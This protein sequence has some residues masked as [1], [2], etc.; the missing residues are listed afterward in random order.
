MTTENIEEL[1]A[2]LLGADFGITLANQ[3]VA[4]VRKEY[5]SQG[6]NG[7]SIFEIAR[8]E[9]ISCFPLET[10]GLK[11]SD[12]EYPVVVSLIGVN[13]VGKTTTAAKLAYRVAKEGQS[14]M[15]AACDTFRAAAIEQLK[16]WGNR[17]DVPVIAGSYGADPASVAHDAVC[18][19]ISNRINYLF[20]D[21]AGRLHTKNNLMQELQKV[22]RVIGKRL[23]DAPHEVLLVVDATTGMNALIQ[24]KEFNKIVQISGIVITKLD[25]T[26]RGGM[27]TAI[28]KELSLP[29]KFIGLG[30]Q[31]D[32]LQPFDAHQYAE[33]IFAE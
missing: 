19:A 20:V 27:V 22:H 14:S 11:A 10:K 21:T 3:I 28:Q 7:K 8:N 9:I 24:A 25:G 12:S 5:E 30:E 29:V 18:S 26:S 6:K 1:E 15:L 33:A 13:G 23:N 4:A 17:L 2:V 16:L 32:D 31:P